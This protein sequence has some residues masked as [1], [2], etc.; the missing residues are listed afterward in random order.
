MGDNK[1][2]TLSDG[3]K[4][5]RNKQAK[6]RDLVKA[7]RAAGKDEIKRK[8][9]LIAAQLLFDGQPIAFE[10][11]LEIGTEDFTK[12]SFELFADEAEAFT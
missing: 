6:V 2:V 4:V 1:Q 3:R 9:F 8:Y 11:I 10:E 5:T 7:E 12:L